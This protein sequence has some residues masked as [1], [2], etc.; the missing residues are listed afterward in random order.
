MCK[1][2]LNQ[3][4]LQLEQ[5]IKHCCHSATS[6]FRKLIKE[7]AQN[8]ILDIQSDIDNWINL[9]DEREIACYELENLLQSKC[10]AYWLSEKA[11]KYNCCEER[12]ISHNVI[13]QIIS[14]S[15]TNTYLRVLF[16]SKTVS[17]KKKAPEFIWF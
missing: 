8:I 15:V 3:I 11:N 2:E 5:E 12:E 10:D 17:H 1:L 9:L 14:K 16:P 4:Y 6:D 13:P 7:D